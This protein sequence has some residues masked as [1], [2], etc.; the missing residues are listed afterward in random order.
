[1]VFDAGQCIDL[2]LVVEP[3][4][5]VTLRDA[6]D[7]NDF[8]QILVRAD[9]STS[10]DAATFLLTPTPEPAAIPIA[11]GFLLRCRHRRRCCG[12]FL[13]TKRDRS[14]DFQNHN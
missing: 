13:D 5:N 8:G 2:N 9:V 10:Y 1:V 12:L 6:V 11:F 3:V 4:A 14:L 7:I